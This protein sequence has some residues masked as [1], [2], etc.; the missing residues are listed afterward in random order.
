MA[1][2][3]AKT[4]TPAT[5]A[6]PAPRVPPQRVVWRALPD[7]DPAAKDHYIGTFCPQDA[8]TL[9]SQLNDLHDGR[10]IYRA[11]PLTAS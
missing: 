2:D 3:Q 11:A 5:P 10:R 4:E 7:T 1:D 9:V 6:T 8:A